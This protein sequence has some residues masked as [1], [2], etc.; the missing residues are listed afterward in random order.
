MESTIEKVNKFIQGRDPMERIVCMECGYDDDR[1]SIIYNKENGEKR[2]KMEDFHPFVWVK[3][4]ACVRMFDGD[5]KELKRTMDFYGIKCKALATSVGETKDKETLE[6]LENGYRYMFYASKRM[7]FSKFQR[8]FTIAKTPIYPRRKKNEPELKTKDKEFL[9]VAPIE[10]HMIS[11]GKRLFKGYNG[12]DE[13]KRLSFDLETTGLEFR[14]DHI[15]QIGIR[16]NKGFE[17][18]ISIKGDTLQERIEDEHRATEEFLQIL[19]KEKPDVLFGHNSE[20][21]DWNMLIENADEY[22]E[23]FEDMSAKYFPHPIYKKNKESV[24]KLGGEVEYFKPTVM[25]GFNVLDSMH[26]VRRAQAL[27]S[28]MKSA[29]LKYVTKYLKLKKENRVYV[30]GN[31]IGEIWRET[32]EKSYAFNNTNG[33]YYKVENTEESLKEGYE[34]T[35]GKYI[36]ERYL[37]DDIWETDKVELKLNEAN[38]LISKILPTSFSRACT[39]G[40]A[41]IW[42]LIVLAWCYENNLA[43]P[44][45]GES[46][47][48]TGG[49]SRLLRVGYADRIVKLDYNSLYPSIILTWNLASKLDVSGALLSMLEYVLTQ[50]EFYKGLKG[51]A[52]KKAKKLEEELEI[53]KDSLSEKEIHDLKLEIQKFKAEE[54][55]NDKNQLPLKILGNSFFGS[56]G[57]PN[58]FPL[59]DTLVAENTTCIGRMCLRLMISHFTNLGYSPIVGDSFTGDTPLFIKYKENGMLD[60]KPISEIIDEGSIKIDALGREYDTS[61]KNFYVLCRSGW[62]EIEYVYRHDTDKAIYE[63]SDTSN[64]MSVEI[65]EDH[66]LYDSEQQK[67]TPKN[68]DKDTKLEYYGKFVSGDTTNEYE[69]KC[70][71]LAVKYLKEGKHDRLGCWTLNMTRSNSAYLLLKLEGFEPQN[72]TCA[73]QIMYLK[74]KL[75]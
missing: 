2:C 60:I 15:D 67:I 52:G 63:V 7:S 4:S 16:T 51:A 35:S 6:R 40:T 3:G 53:K 65:T 50:R 31:K 71:D 72:K 12:Y 59:G 39:M 73:A 61:K 68:I 70:I 45:F 21:F 62:H 9:C 8:F 54:S 10:Q 17:K 66:S 47:T 42:K 34:Y 14:K 74:K 33:E 19:A 46:V 26:A 57:A 18:V 64:G 36:V 30:Q 37:L 55:A 29:N 23:K 13:L 43:V 56:E 48:F 20:N 22:G 41:S 27:D 69:K 44:S 11:T 32:D 5:R 38:F 28:S 58:V 1:V 49:L 24:L 25:W 75:L